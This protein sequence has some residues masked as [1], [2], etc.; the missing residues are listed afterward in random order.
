MKTRAETRVRRESYKGALLPLRD[1]GAHHEV[2]DELIAGVDEEELL[3][4]L[5]EERAGVLHRHD[6]AEPNAERN[7]EAADKVFAG[8]KHSSNDESEKYRADETH[9]EGLT[10]HGARL[11][12]HGRFFFRRIA[13]HAHQS[14]PGLGEEDWR[15][16]QKAQNH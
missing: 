6:E 14:H 5:G 15:I 12:L 16:P 8:D 10:V 4:F 3:G 9:H 7:F 13:F 11:F 2:A 1:D